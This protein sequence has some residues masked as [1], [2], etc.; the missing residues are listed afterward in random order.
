MSD[1]VL[2]SF[3]TWRAAAT[4]GPSTCPPKL[5]AKEEPSAQEKASHV[6]RLLKIRAEKICSGEKVAQWLVR[7]ER[8]SK[9]RDCRTV[10]APRISIETIKGLLNGLAGF[11]LL[12]KNLISQKNYGNY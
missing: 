4:T 10:A 7:E 11:Q 6:V 9:C 12:L 8:V 1:R 5:L 2:G 3:G